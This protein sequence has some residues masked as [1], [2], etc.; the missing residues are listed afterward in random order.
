MNIDIVQRVYSDGKDVKVQA[1]AP[2]KRTTNKS[3]D[4]FLCAVCSFGDF[5][6][7]K[8]YTPN[9]CPNCG[10]IVKGEV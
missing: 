1:Y 5:G 3:K 4:G 9:Y 7:F 6:L 8:D 2:V 10:A